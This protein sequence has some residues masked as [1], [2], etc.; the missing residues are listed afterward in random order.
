MTTKTPEHATPE[1]I[2]ETLTEK[3]RPLFIGEGRLMSGLFQS[4]AHMAASLI[5][6]ASSGMPSIE[7]AAAHVV[8][9]AIEARRNMAM[10]DPILREIHMKLF[11]ET[12]RLAGKRILGTVLTAEML[13]RSSA[14]Q[15]FQQYS[16][17]NLPVKG[18]DRLLEAHGRAYLDLI[19]AAK[20]QY[21]MSAGLLKP[22]DIA[23]NILGSLAKLNAQMTD[24][25]FAEAFTITLQAAKDLGIE[26]AGE[27]Q[28]TSFKEDDT[29]FL[30]S[31][32]GG[33]TR[34]MTGCRTCKDGD[35]CGQCR[36]CE[37]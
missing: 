28:D 30:S 21:D 32:R 5:A 16:R 37:H 9:S 12:A 4:P 19:N 14:W 15:D 29:L 17:V 10:Q 33:I 25:A 20:S 7:A 36:C 13:E 3:L 6:S 35:C 23:A 11:A 1:H 31:E 26:V 8:L 2:T 34:H 27:D 22:D 24:N 18:V